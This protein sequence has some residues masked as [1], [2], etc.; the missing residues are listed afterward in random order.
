MADIF[1]E[2]DE[3]VRRDK[4]EVLWQKYGKYVIA[5]AL[6][7]V[8][9]TAANV[10]WREYNNN[11]RLAEGEKFEAAQKHFA[12]GDYAAAANAFGSLVNEAGA[13]YALVAKFRQAAALADGKDDA[14]AIAAL[15][16][17]A[18]DSGND[19]MFRDLASLL[20]ASRMLDGGN[21]SGARKNLEPLAGKGKAWRY[22][23]MEMLALASLA[24]GDRENALKAFKELSDDAKAPQ[25][26]RSRSTEMI[27]ALGGAE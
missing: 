7:V 13:G 11:Q 25:G 22:S 8:L 6:A 24:D 21:I 10:A 15:N 9:A 18:V 4:Y 20:A 19:T 27:A 2:V 1:Q 12:A 3:E 23:A 17:I 14:G 5:V 16:A 26:V